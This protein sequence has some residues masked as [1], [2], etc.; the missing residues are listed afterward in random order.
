MSK[1]LFFLK[2][3]PIRK[4][5]SLLVLLFF[6]ITR[7]DRGK[8][9]RLFDTELIESRSILG[10][11]Y[12]KNGSAR[13]YDAFMRVSFHFNNTAVEINLRWNSSD[14]LVF[15]QVFIKEEYG[16]LFDKTIHSPTIF[17]AGA[18]IG[19]TTIYLKTLYPNARI[20]SV[21]PDPNNFDTL[22][23]NIR[24]CNLDNVICVQS[25]L[26]YIDGTVRL[27]RNFRDQ[28]D[29]SVKVQEDGD[30]QVPARRM[31]SILKQMSVEQIDILKMDIEGAELD[32]FKYDSWV[33]EMLRSLRYIAIEV[34]DDR[35]VRIK[36][37]LTAAGF[38]IFKEGETLFGKNV[39]W[40][41][42]KS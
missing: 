3:Y 13:A 28:R 23:K 15:E 10:F 2:A 36:T 12:E 37:T 38:S 40:S 32:I 21:E 17:D 41:E 39:G 30:T 24:I 1:F 42:G 14:F 18:N 29:W 27:A 8:W 22:E 5:F 7:V 33:V 16:H 34:H 11:I 31:L 26:W 6:E 19:C 35:D 4:K 9:Q 25:A 20:I